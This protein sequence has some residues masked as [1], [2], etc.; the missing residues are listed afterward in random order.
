MQDIHDRASEIDVL[1]NQ[2]VDF[3]TEKGKPAPTTITSSS[4]SSKKRSYSETFPTE[5]RDQYIH[6]YKSSSTSTSS[7]LHESSF[8]RDKKLKLS[9]IDK[10]FDIF[11]PAMRTTEVAPEFVVMLI[12]IHKNNKDNEKI[13]VNE[14]K[15]YIQ[16]V[17]DS[18]S[19]KDDVLE[20][21]DKLTLD[22]LMEHFR[23]LRESFIKFAY[24]YQGF[25]NLNRSDQ[26]T[27][28]ERN[29]L[30][31]TVVSIWIISLCCLN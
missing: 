7:I 26:Q 6:P 23:Q 30:L 17:D 2:Y 31:F 1:E 19:A 4:E 9:K 21:E 25:Q 16:C 10:I 28:L 18:G 13:A 27:L 24:G 14:K 29:S 11:V 5:N 15:S 22:A 8:S 12:N 3:F 20:E